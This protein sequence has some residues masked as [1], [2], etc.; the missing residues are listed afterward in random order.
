[1]RFL[2]ADDHSI[3]RI[4]LINIIKKEFPHAEF[5]EMSDGNDVI[6]FVRKKKYELL[7]LD[8]NMPGSD[9]HNIIDQVRVVENTQKILLISMNPEKVY[10]LRYFKSGING[11]VEKTASDEKILSAVRCVLAGKNYM[12]EDLTEL[13]VNSYRKGDSGN[14]FDKLS[15]REFEIA[16]YLDKG[17]APGEIA[18]IMSLHTSTVGTYKLRIF[19][20]LKVKNII[21][22]HKMVETYRLAVS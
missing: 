13:M 4:G 3:V 1:M 22:L 10:A 7:V 6:T 15:S 21:D 5:D 17:F 2:I 16:M 19:E 11:Y 18:N 20:K 14:P 9:M 12:S 8:V